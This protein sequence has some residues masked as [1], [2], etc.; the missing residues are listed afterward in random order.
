[1]T[2]RFKPDTVKYEHFSA[3]IFVNTNNTVES[4]NAIRVEGSIFQISPSV[5]EKYSNFKISPNPVVSTATITTPTLDDIGTNQ[6]LEIIIHD[7]QGN[8]V[9]SKNVIPSTIEQN[10]TFIPKNNGTF[11]VTLRNKDQN[12]STKLFQVVK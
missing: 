7:L 2:I 9:F 8:V 11:S 12:L 4:I 1:M 6:E 10:I 3:V 5:N